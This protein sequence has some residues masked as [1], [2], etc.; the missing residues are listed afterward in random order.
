[1]RPGMTPQ[2]LA[3][4]KQQNIYQK[5]R[6][7]RILESRQPNNYGFSKSFMDIL[8]SKRHNHVH[9]KLFRKKS[10]KAMR[11]V[12]INIFRHSN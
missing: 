8:E 11:N 9:L 6:L 12:N 3:L 7:E 5:R 1:M 2:Q 4:I 10:D